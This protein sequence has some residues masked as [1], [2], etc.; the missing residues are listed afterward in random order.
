MNNREDLSQIYE[1]WE[2]NRRGVLVCET[3]LRC[4]INEDLREELTEYLTRMRHR[5][6]MLRG[7]FEELQ[8]DPDEQTPRTTAVRHNGLTLV[9]AMERALSDGDPVTAQLV[10]VECVVEA[11]LRRGGAAEQD[12]AA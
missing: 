5:E 9:M 2:S 10:A 11:G 6:Q 4:V 3:A 7:V 8:L 12:K 1:A